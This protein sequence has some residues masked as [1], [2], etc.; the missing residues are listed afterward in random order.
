[1]HSILISNVPLLIVE[2]EDLL[3][4]MK[5][6]WALSEM[7]Y[8]IDDIINYFFSIPIY[9]KEFFPKVYLLLNLLLK[10]IVETIFR[11]DYIPDNHCNLYKLT[12]FY[13]LQRGVHNP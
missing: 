1:M 6:I 13:F 3:Q 4:T 12:Q 9:S 5:N 10:H 7:V 11:V 8:W 2:G